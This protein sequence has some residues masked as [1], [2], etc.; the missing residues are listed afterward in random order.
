MAHVLWVDNFSKVFRKSIP[1]SSTGTYNSACGLGML[2]LLLTT[3]VSIRLLKPII[4]VKKY[5]E[6]PQILVMMKV[7]L[8]L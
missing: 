3:I 5:M 4:A 7:L 1:T 6:C 2:H 8:E